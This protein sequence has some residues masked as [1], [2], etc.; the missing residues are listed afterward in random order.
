[1]NYEQS[2]ALQDRI[3]RS[4]SL[5]CVTVLPYTSGHTISRDWALIIS[6]IFTGSACLVRSAD[7]LGLM[8]LLGEHVNLTL[9]PSVALELALECG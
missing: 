4:T 7:D 9:Q 3:L 6:H 1:M 8:V 5:Y 2:S